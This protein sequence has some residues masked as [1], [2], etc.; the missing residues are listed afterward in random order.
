MNKDISRGRALAKLHRI[1]LQARGDDVAP[2]DG[3]VYVIEFS[4]KT[5]KVGCTRDLAARSLKHKR[6]G[7]KFGLTVTR[8]WGSQAHRDYKPTEKLLK[9]FAARESRLQGGSEYFSG[10]SFESAVEFVESLPIRPSTAEQVEAF[11]ASEQERRD[12]YLVWREGVEARRR[13][14]IEIEIDD[15]LAAWPL[16]MLFC[17]DERLPDMSERA[18]PEVMDELIDKAEHLASMTGHEGDDFGLWSAMDWLDYMID[19]LLLSAKDR[20]RSRV[21]SESRFDLLEPLSGRN[22]S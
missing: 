22:A 16:R 18:A 13:S 6:D 9:E 14:H 19:E 12:Q 1:P 5:I 17:S 15:H 3:F 7:E 21:I 8:Q 2:E 20:L 10:L 4:D 11:L